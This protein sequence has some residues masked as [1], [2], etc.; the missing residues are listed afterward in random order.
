MAYAGI[1][2]GE[3][4]QGNSDPYFHAISIN[5]IYNNV[6]TGSASNC[7][8]E[9]NISNTAPT[10]VPVP[11]Y[12]IPYGTAFILD[13]EATDLEADNLT[14][15]WEQTDNGVTSVPPASTSTNGALFRSM[16]PTEASERYFPAKTTVIS[17]NLSNNWE[18]IPDVAR[19]MNFA[20]TVRDNNIV[21]GQSSR[22]DVNIT[23]ANTI[24]QTKI[25]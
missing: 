11:D 5:E 16:D 9:T 6:S 17:G 14:Y 22:E 19:E 23:V 3:N 8:T 15:T 12:T 13:C 24:C 4:V 2:P 25:Y 20:V 7:P 18:V 10:I 21:G 1:C